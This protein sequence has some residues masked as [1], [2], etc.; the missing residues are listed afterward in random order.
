MFRLNKLRGPAERKKAIRRLTSWPREEISL[1][2]AIKGYAFLFSRINQI[3]LKLYNY[4]LYLK[5][6]QI[7]CLHPNK[8]KNLKI[9][10]YITK[11]NNQRSIF[12]LE[13]RNSIW[14]A[15]TI[16]YCQMLASVCW[17]LL[18]AGPCKGWSA[19]VSFPP[20]QLDL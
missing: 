16:S 14:K 4:T 13:T 8:D 18:T 12:M 9:I 5:I 7:G 6:L 19:K 3:I 15:D 1:C 20:L 10:E 17:P 2:S 11:N